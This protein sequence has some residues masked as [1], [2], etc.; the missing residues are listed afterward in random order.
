MNVVIISP[1]YDLQPDVA[2]QSKQLAEAL[3]T[4]GLH[5]VRLVEVVSD[6]QN[7]NSNAD[8]FIEREEFSSYG[9]VAEYLNHN[10][11]ICFL[12]HG[13]N[14]YG[15]HRGRFIL[16]LVYKLNKPL[17]TICH[18]VVNNPTT[19]EKNVLGA[20]AA[21]S[22]KLVAL[23]QL[24]F[25]FLEHFYKIN[26]EKIVRIERGIPVIA[27]DDSESFLKKLQ[28][29]GKKVILS[30]GSLQPRKGYETVIN[31]LPS[32]L[33]HH[34]DI[35][36]LIAGKTENTELNKRG[37]EYRQSLM[38]LAQR[39]G[40]A[41]NVVFY[42]HDVNGEDMM[43][44]ISEC[45][46]YVSSTLEERTLDSLSLTMAVGA[47]AMVLSTPSW[48]A[49]ELLDDQRGILFPFK[50]S[51]DLSQHI[52]NV[53]R[54]ERERKMYKENA[55]LY[56]AQYI[57][58]V[59]SLK[60]LKL[61]DKCGGEGVANKDSKS[62][63]NPLFLPAKRFDHLN[64]LTNKTGVLSRSLNEVIDFKSGYQLVDNALALQLLA[65][66]QRSN[67]VDENLDKIQT[68]LSSI[69]YCEN[70][71][72][73]WSSGFGFDNERK[74]RASEFDIG[75]TAWSLGVLYRYTDSHYLKDSAFVMLHKLLNQ[76]IEISD[77]KAKAACVIG[78]SYV[79]DDDGAEPEL[80]NLVKRFANNILRL[81]PEDNIK[82]PWYEAEMS[83]SFAL[84]PAALAHAYKVI[85]DERYL[86]AARRSC[87]FIERLLFAEGMF[88]PAIKGMCNG[89]V[90][91]RKGL[92]Q[93]AMEAY[94]LVVCYAELYKVSK[95]PLYLKQL[96]KTHHWYL[97]EN[98]IFKSLYD[99]SSGACYSALGS[100]GIVAE[101]ATAS[102]CAY[103][104][105]HYTYLEIYFEE[106]K[107]LM[108][109]CSIE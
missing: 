69:A 60:Y 75:I 89:D 64:K 107:E 101:K 84:I 76:N 39:R 12:Q 31:C 63:I 41:R 88:N 1:C 17:I 59:L 38:M 16:D 105:S 10:A 78:I 91:H 72:G 3:E 50:S 44:L 80:F 53:L 55:A 106:I 93:D 108:I 85:G 70:E 26:S 4:S 25:D 5:K 58:P 24:G 36:Y 96:A 13:N 2:I 68:Y 35:V 47:G 11:D 65:L 27:K 30:S 86:S 102:T 32:L 66:S 56:G 23:S 62:Q 51:T 104:L 40:V 82:W 22:E 71:N 95:E 73:T 28:L 43:Q 54:S 46:L 109:G 33:N 9:K 8:L 49:K 48:F 79:I 34:R 45:Q 20:L 52:L 103:W 77:I 98:N 19:N 81:L 21:K 61:I 94:Y 37:E 15:G 6:L 14:V 18:S 74:K 97:G 87:R 67:Q 100:R 99:H 29:D 57:W 7:V 42:D 83:D 90:K 92:D